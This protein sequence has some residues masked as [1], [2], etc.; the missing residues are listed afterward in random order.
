[1]QYKT[2][3][4]NI[5]STPRKLRLVADM[6]KNMEPLEAVE[7]LQFTNKRAALPLLK[8]IKTVIANAEGK[9][10]LKFKSIEINEGPKLK[11]FMFGTAGRHTGRPFKKR[12][13]QIKIIL[14]DE[15][16]KEKNGTKD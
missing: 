10:D 16:I 5:N 11:R 15:V 14:T 3:Q 7:L 12:L 1:M 8:A 9:V 13:S 2:V 6:I 4:K